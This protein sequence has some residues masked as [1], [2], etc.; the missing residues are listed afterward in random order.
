MEI[1][2]IGDPKSNSKEKIKAEHLRLVTG[3]PW[4]MIKKERLF[5]ETKEHDILRQ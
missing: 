5:L 4:R 1:A 2:K 3:T